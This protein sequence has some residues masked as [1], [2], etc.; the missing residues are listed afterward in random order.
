MGIKDIIL[1]LESRGL[2]PIKVSENQIKININKDNILNH[3]S[4]IQSKGFIHLSFISGVDY[5]EED[6]F[7]VV[8][9]TYSYEDKIHILN[10]VRIDRKNPNI[11]SVVSLW[12]QAQF[13]EQEVHEF[14]GIYFEGNK[15]LSK[16]FLE[17]YLD[18]PPLR[19]DFDTRKYS[20]KA[21]G[22]NIQGGGM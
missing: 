13:Y 22:A 10:K 20:I 15:D 5:I 7:E 19:K 4:Y 14:F 11:D 21:F 8:Y 3:L 9:H 16:L 17:N 12:E 2:E 6:E 1:D 18:V